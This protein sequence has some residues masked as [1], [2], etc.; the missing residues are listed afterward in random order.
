MLQNI[1]FTTVQCIW[2]KLSP[3]LHSTMVLTQ[4]RGWIKLY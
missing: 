2:N 3:I 1:Y 4:I